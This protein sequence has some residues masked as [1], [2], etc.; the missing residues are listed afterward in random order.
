MLIYYIF[1]LIEK[2]KRTR[3]KKHKNSDIE[4]PKEPSAMEGAG[5]NGGTAA[6]SGKSTKSQFTKSTNE[7]NR[8]KA[9]KQTV[10]M[11]TPP[12]NSNAPPKE[13]LFDPITKK[14]VKPK[15]KAKNKSNC[16]KTDKNQEGQVIEVDSHPNKNDKKC[17]KNIGQKNNDK[18]SFPPHYIDEMVEKGLKERMLIEGTIRINPKCYEDAFVSRGINE[19]DI[20]V[21]GMM[22][23]NR[24]LN[25]DE[26]VVDIL[27]E[28]DWRVNN[29]LV[30]EYLSANNLEDLI[31]ATSEAASQ[32]TDTVIT[33]KR[34][35]VK[36]TVSKETPTKEHPLNELDGLHHTTSNDLING[37]E[38]E[39]DCGKVQAIEKVDSYDQES[40]SNEQ[41]SKGECVPLEDLEEADFDGVNNSTGVTQENLS[42]CE[43]LSSSDGID[44]VVD[45][46]V[47]VNHNMPTDEDISNNSVESKLSELNISG[48]TKQDQKEPHKTRRKRGSKKNKTKETG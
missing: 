3:R 17:T 20:Y 21:G 23:R 25:G 35:G 36:F 14:Y 18:H 26:V 47:E 33:F 32:S 8:Q 46:V 30:E 9:N 39:S 40:Y 43:S 31:S 5:R 45:E 10:D 7:K 27:P 4:S 22:Y 16:A 11:Q 48:Q 44:I 28:A 41:K 1:T 38:S 29:E 19:P 24:A 15:N 42:D 2:K 34:L 37:L 12:C 6:K 13:K